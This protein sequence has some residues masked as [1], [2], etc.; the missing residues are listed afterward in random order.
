LY[1]KTS[2]PKALFPQFLKDPGL[3]LEKS[4]IPK[5]WSFIGK[6]WKTAWL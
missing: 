1:K 6:L 3:T 5:L 2:Y 4:A